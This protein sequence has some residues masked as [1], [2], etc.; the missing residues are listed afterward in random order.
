MKGTGAKAKWYTSFLIGALDS[1][2]NQVIQIGYV[3]SGFSERA[4]D[5][6]REEVTKLK[7]SEEK[8]RVH[9]K[10][11]LIFQIEFQ[12][13]QKSSIKNTYALRFPVYV[14]VRPDKTKNDITEIDYLKN[15]CSI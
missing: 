5:Y 10:P 13:V 4:L 15:L 12:E 11:N 14:S 2:T 8:N 1:E 3:G 9:L 7:I 6:L